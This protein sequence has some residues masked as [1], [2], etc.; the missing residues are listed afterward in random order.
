MVYMTLSQI[1]IIFTERLRTIY[2]NQ[3][4]E[5]IFKI[6]ARHVL[7]YSKIDIHLYKDENILS[8]FEN[9][10]MAILDRLSSGEPVQYILGETEFYGL[11]LKVDHR[12]LIP[13]QE[14]EYMVDIVIHSL[15]KEKPLQII[16]LC[17]GSGCIAIA[18][19][20]NLPNAI[21]TATDIS[22]NAISLATENSIA[23]KA[24][25]NFRLDNLLNPENNLDFYDCIISNPP[26]VR[27]LEKMQ[28]HRNVL[29][30]EP[31]IALF[32]ADSDPL[33]F[34]RALTSYAKTHLLKDS[35]I[36]VE[37]NENLG[38]ETAELF[39]NSNFSNVE[40]LKDLQNKDRYIKARKNA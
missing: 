25:I 17:T 38:L 35:L 7:N 39:H 12:V 14:T 21:I 5:S 26:Y 29:D 32:V 40:I 20:K 15:P 36:M 10:L 2:P 3:E 4:I 8:S 19:A 9:K 33:L 34:Y 11:T 13:R 18:L 28:M 24:E 31:A 1:K 16:D 6:V 27:E 23:C 30:F 37:I 22:K